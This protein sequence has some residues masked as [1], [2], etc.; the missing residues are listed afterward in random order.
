LT[1]GTVVRLGDVMTSITSTTIDQPMTI[2][3]DSPTTS[4]RAVS[5]CLLADRVIIDARVAVTSTRFADTVGLDNLRFR[6]DPRW[7][8]RHRRRTLAD[9][10][11]LGPGGLGV[12]QLEL[13]YRQ[14][15][16][17]LEAS[18]SH[19]GANDFYWGELDCRRR[20]ART[21]SVDRWLLSIYRVMFGYGVRAS[22]PLTWWVC[23]T[24]LLAWAFTFHPT[25]LWLTKAGS[26]V[27]N[28][29]P[30]RHFGEGLAFVLQNST[31]ILRSIDTG[32]SWQGTLVVLVSRFVTLSLLAGA[33]LAVRSRITR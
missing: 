33:L 25:R 24:G 23:I 21:P 13:L 2:T 4:L 6:G 32:L 27:G 28:D 16:A 18:R 14:L 1:A 31:N 15:R 19:A 30:I 5:G 20:H 3:S 11:G 9:D 7:P 17:S 12:D 22:R 8:I 10:D 29:T 26:G